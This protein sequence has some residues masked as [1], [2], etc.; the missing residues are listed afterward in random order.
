MGRKASMTMTP[1]GFRKKYS[2]AGL[3]GVPLKSSSFN[4]PRTPPK[5]SM[6]SQ[7]QFHPSI[8]DIIAKND[9]KDLPKES[10]GSRRSIKKPDWYD[11]SSEEESPGLQKVKSCFDTDQKSQESPGHRESKSRHDDDQK[12][13]KK[14]D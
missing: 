5:G 3:L 9:T 7:S 13:H 2:T 11:S 10:Q 1:E 14:M 8:R 12:S 6:T 4:G